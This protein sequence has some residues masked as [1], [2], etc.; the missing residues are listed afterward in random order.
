MGKIMIET[1]KNVGMFHISPD[2]IY[3]RFDLNHKRY[4]IYR[5]VCNGLEY[6]V[7]ANVNK[8]NAELGI[9]LMNIPLEAV[10]ELV[11]YIFTS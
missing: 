3:N 4:R 7:E 5:I 11:K 10:E 2:F 6:F 1:I 8:G 9:W